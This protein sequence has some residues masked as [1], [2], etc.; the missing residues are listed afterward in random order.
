MLTGL[1]YVDLL[2]TGLMMGASTFAVIFYAICMHM[3][4]PK[5]GIANVL[6]QT[7]YRVLRIVHVVL[8]SIAAIALYVSYMDGEIEMFTL[9]ILK[10][11]FLFINA[12]IAIAM[13]KKMLSV[14]WGAPAI[15][16]TW[17]TLGLFSIYAVVMQEVPSV[18]FALGLY[19]CVLGAMIGVFYLIRLY[20][21]PKTTKK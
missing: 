10:V 20:L 21:A 9:Y 16:G 7:V 12:M 6:V 2:A 19:L 14:Y 15:A 18:L 17:H 11:F 8:F 5:D 3:G 1:T 4:Y 13:K